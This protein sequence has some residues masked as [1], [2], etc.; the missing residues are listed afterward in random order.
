VE[1]K[2]KNSAF[3]MNHIIITR[4]ISPLNQMREYKLKEQTPHLVNLGDR[5][6]RKVQ[7]LKEDK[8]KNVNEG[9]ESKKKKR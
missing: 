3:I 6:H 7:R 8:S 2:N 5:R 9:V 4:L 1:K